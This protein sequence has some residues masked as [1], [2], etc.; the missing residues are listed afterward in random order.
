MWRL[1]CLRIV[2]LRDRLTHMLVYSDFLISVQ[3]LTTALCH[4]KSI[5]RIYCFLIGFQ[6]SKRPPTR[7]TF[8]DLNRWLGERTDSFLNYKGKWTSLCFISPIWYYEEL[9][10]T[11]GDFV[12]KIALTAVWNLPASRVVF[13]RN[14]WLM[15][16]RK[17]KECAANTVVTLF[18]K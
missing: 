15:S 17:I 14:S 1:K 4:I 18:R 7:G 11:K 2:G 13:R 3:K 9:S 10:N 16:R 12:W 5:T 6:I 8:T